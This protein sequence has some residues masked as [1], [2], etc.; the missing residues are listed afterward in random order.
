[1]TLLAELALV[2]IAAVGVVV[3]LVRLPRTESLHWRRAGAVP[4]ARP[5]PL[6]RMEGLVSSAGVSALQ[7]HAYLR[8]LLADLAS[9]RLAARGQVLE[10]IPDALGR[11]LLGEALWEIV[12]PGRPF[13]EDRHGPGVSAAELR[14]MLDT[15]ERL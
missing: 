9:S 1:M 10:R 14:V 2:A 15:L 8:P 11:E 3:C 13:P 12:R 4:S 7:A 6:V 5:E